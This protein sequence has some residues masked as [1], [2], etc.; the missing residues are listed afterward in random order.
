MPLV[1]TSPP[2]ESD[3]TLAGRI[4]HGDLSPFETIMRLHNRMLYRIAR[5]IVR[6]DAEGED[7]LQSAYLLAYQSIAPFSGHAKIS[8][9]HARIVTNEALGRSRR[10][11]RQG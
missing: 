5:S 3:R 11:A 8:T 9:W 1:L 10:T 6:D 2:A 7:C 4:A